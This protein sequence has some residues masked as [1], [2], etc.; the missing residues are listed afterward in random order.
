M[1]QDFMMIREV[2][3]YFPDFLLAPKANDIMHSSHPDG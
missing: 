2:F 3:L 1:E